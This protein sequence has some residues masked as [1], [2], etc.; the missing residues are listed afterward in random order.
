[1][2]M[3]RWGYGRA[4]RCCVL[5][6]LLGTLIQ[7][8]FGPI[9]KH[10]LHYPWS[11]VSA[12]VYV[13]ALVLI[14]SLSGKYPRLRRLS[15]PYASFASIASVVVLSVLFGLIPQ[16]ETAS[17]PASLLGWTDMRHCWAFN[18]LMLWMMT[19]IGLSVVAGFR[20]L[21]SRRLVSTLSHLA[22]F[23]VL[24][25]GF[26]GNGDKQEVYVTAERDVPVSSGVD[27]ADQPVEL[28]FMLTLRDFTIE[29]YPA[30]LRLTDP[31]TGRFAPGSV[32]A[33]TVGEPAS[34]GE[35]SLEVLAFYDM[36][37]RM[38]GDTVY[39][40][41]KHVGACPAAQVRAI[42]GEDCVEGW[43]SCGSFL[44][45]EAVLDLG[46]GVMV[47]MPR[48]MPKRYVSDVQLRS[49]KKGEQRVEIAVNHP[50]RL[51]PW[52]IYQYDY[53][54]TRGRWSN[55][56]GLL[57]VKDGWYPL[58]AAGLWLL[59]GAG[60]LMFFTAGGS[61]KKKEEKQ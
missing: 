8:V 46:G 54:M 33:E 37:T 2:K 20:Q 53:D 60:V 16:S 4:F 28:P 32:S 1:M 9:S 6:F 5:L 18:F 57:C 31:E 3:I 12:L 35:W 24:L 52:T 43:V 49:E 58:I 30:S 26:F 50:A 13:Y 45:D 22:V 10:L 11:V 14:D 41:L 17:G 29:E 21:K 15:D 44:F 34:I 23:L 51:G 47:K 59:L 39:R 55:Q 36:A 56:S 42:R 48:R 38:P 7:L 19:G 25:G 40:E 27:D 61:R